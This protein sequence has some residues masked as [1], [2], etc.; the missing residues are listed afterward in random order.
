MTETLQELT[1]ATVQYSVSCSRHL[2]NGCF[3]SPKATATRRR[4][5]CFAERFWFM[6]KA[7]LVWYQRYINSQQLQKNRT[8]ET[9][10]S[11]DPIWETKTNA[12]RVSNLVIH[13]AVKW[14]RIRGILLY[15]THHDEPLFTNCFL[16]MER[17]YRY[18][19]CD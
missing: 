3:M 18:L 17:L 7:P 5:R 1:T 8:E 13:I 6:P 16:R 9:K 10:A 12:N 14:R 4:S 11:C 15:F 19:F 2:S